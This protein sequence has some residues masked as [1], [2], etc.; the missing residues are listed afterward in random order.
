MLPRSTA[1]VS[2]AETADS[3]LSASRSPELRATFSRHSMKS[4]RALGSSSAAIGMSPN[5]ASAFVSMRLYSACVLRANF[6]SNS[7]DNVYDL[8]RLLNVPTCRSRIIF[9]AAA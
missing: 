3:R 8:T 9:S 6:S 1:H 7:T 4:R 2:I 5:S